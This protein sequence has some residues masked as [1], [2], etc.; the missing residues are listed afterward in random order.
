MNY[1]IFFD[2]KS[3]QSLF[4]LEKILIYFKTLF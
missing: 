2:S 3:S 4:G 1:P